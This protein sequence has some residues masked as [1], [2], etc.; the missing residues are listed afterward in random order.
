MLLLGVAYGLVEEGLAIQS[1][2]NPTL[3]GA[4]DWGAR[5]FGINGVYTLW[6]VGY[7]AVWSVAIPILL[8]DLLFPAE[9][10]KPYLGRV[11]L[12]VTGIFYV[13]GVALIGF[14]L[15]R[16]THYLAP[17]PLLGLT[18][19]VV[20]MLVMAALRLLPRNRPET[21]QP[22]RGPSPWVVLVVASISGFA[23]Q[24][25]LI[26]LRHFVP[27]LFAGAWVVLPMALAVIMAGAVGWLV[28]QWA[29]SRNWSDL[30]LLALASGALVAHTLFGALVLA[31]TPVDRLGL[32]GLGLVMVAM[33]IVLAFRLRARSSYDATP[34]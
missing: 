34:V 11:G 20:A 23:W 18:V 16:S 9:R 27:V 3:F 21:E 12:V 1:C 26:W 29:Q 4:A 7:H 14:F 25:V 10:K 6:A 19:L 15:F 2:F 8:T 17:P 22:E 5:I 13:L 28:Q 31:Q 33:L 24:F 30:H 32:L